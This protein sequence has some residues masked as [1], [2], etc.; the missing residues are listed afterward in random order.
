M[1]ANGTSS[2][3]SKACEDA[4]DGDD[5]EEFDEGEGGLLTQRSPRSERG[6]LIWECE[7]RNSEF[8]KR[9]G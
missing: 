3:Q 5:S 4:D 1:T 6:G 9:E 8:E 7:M 2:T